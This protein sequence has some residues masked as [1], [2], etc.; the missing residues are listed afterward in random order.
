MLKGSFQKDAGAT[1]EV[2]GNNKACRAIRITI[3]FVAA[4]GTLLY[5]T[6]AYRISELIDQKTQLEQQLSSEKHTNES[7]RSSYDSLA[8]LNSGDDATWL[9]LNEDGSLT[10]Y[11][12]QSK[13]LSEDDFLSEYADD[14]TLMAQ[15]TSLKN[16]PKLPV[17]PPKSSNPPVNYEDENQVWDSQGDSSIP[18]E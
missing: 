14:Q 6:S 9:T 5:V 11:T 10:V 12:R 3:V 1:G 13:T 2:N 16:A 4:L 7:L 15:Y 8:E 18:E 17:Q